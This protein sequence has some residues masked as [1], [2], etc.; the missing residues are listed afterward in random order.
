MIEISVLLVSQSRGNRSCYLSFALNN[1]LRRK[2][3]TP[4]LLFFGLGNF[5]PFHY[6]M[7]EWQCSACINVWTIN[8]NLSHYCYQCQTIITPQ[9]C[10]NTTN[11]SQPTSSAEPM[12]ANSEI[13]FYAVS[14]GLIF[15][16]RWWH[17]HVRYKYSL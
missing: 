4:N 15:M 13:S 12:A 11:I 7:F 6:M 5:L 17:C 3:L 8:S 10:V 2:Y 16:E 14:E 9:S 1:M